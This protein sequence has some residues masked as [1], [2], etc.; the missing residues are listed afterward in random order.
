MSGYHIQIP[1][2]SS[3]LNDWG[4]GWRYSIAWCNDHVGQQGVDWRYDLGGN[5]YFVRDQDRT[6]FLLRWGS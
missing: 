6:M 3:H 5:F 2:E 1:P 4:Q